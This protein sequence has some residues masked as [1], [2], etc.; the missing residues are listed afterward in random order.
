[1]KVE[2]KKEEEDDDDEDDDEDVCM[3]CVGRHSVLGP[4]P[5]VLPSPHVMLICH[6][7]A[8]VLVLCVFVRVW[9]VMHCVHVIH[10]CVSCVRCPLQDGGGKSVLAEK[11]DVVAVLIGKLG[12][13]TW[14]SVHIHTGACTHTKHMG[15]HS[16]TVLHTGAHT[17]STN[18]P[19]FEDAPHIAN[20]TPHTTAHRGCAAQVLWWR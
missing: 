4:G 7:P 16:H 11:L 14:W 6:A 1:V 5:C 19:C 9:T 18:T 3:P 20:R 15:I 17:S 2:N 13:L 12:E 10:G 8:C